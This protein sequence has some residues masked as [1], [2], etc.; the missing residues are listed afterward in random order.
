MRGIGNL[1]GAIPDLLGRTCE[2]I[3]AT[4]LVTHFRLTKRLADGLKVE[5]KDT[6]F[7]DRDLA[8]FGVKHF[9]KAKT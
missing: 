5:E 1:S 8:G 7:W 3:H 6:N 2:V 4:T 9:T